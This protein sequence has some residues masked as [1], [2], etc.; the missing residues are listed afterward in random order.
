MAMSV[1]IM[2]VGIAIP[3][4]P[5]GPYLGFT[6]LPR[7]YW[8]LITLTLLCYVSLTQLAKSWLLRRQWI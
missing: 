2:A 4:S 1:M 3:F 7:L 5:L 6:P 8:P